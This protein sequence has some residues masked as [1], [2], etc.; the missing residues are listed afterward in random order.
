MFTAL[1]GAAIG[2]GMSMQSAINS[3]LRNYVLSPFIASMISFIIGTIFLSIIVLWNGLPLAPPLN[4]FSEQPAWI[5]LGGV[6][7]V[8]ALTTNIF[9]F[10][11]I[12]S[13]ETAIM[14]II[15]MIVTGMIIDNFGLFNSIVQTFSMNRLFGVILI[16]AGVFLAVVIQDLMK[17][18]HY[19]NHN[20]N[21]GNVNKWPWRVAGFIGGALLAVQAAINGELGTA[22]NSPFTAAFISFFVGA[23]A[24]VIIVIIRDKSFTAVKNPIVQKAPLWVWLGGIFGGFYILINIFL[25]GEIGTGPTVVLVL[26]GQI[27][28]SLLV[29]QF[30]LFKSPKNTIVPIQFIGLIIMLAGVVLINLF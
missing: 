3:G 12:G 20:T 10:P 11:K 14:P 8:I 16:L 9:I 6:C 29:Q 22:V 15:G 21:G 1:L 24:L 26:F 17:Q 25:V 23:A 13:V 30:G 19:K 5:W 27:T 28:G 18:K 4:T 7:G 2:T